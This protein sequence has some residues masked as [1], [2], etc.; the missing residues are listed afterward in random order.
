MQLTKIGFVS[1]LRR[2]EGAAAQSLGGAVRGG[3]DGGRGSTR[4]GAD[5]LV[6]APVHAAAALHEG[7]NIGLDEALRLVQ[8]AAVVEDDV[9][10][11]A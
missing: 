4:G 8:V 5:S 3:R 9:E 11:V 1:A 2:L 6:G 10:E 7:G